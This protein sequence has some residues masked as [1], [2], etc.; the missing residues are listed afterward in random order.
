MLLATAAMSLP[1][2][3][4]ATENGDTANLVESPWRIR[5]EIELEYESERN[6]NLDASDDEDEAVFEPEFDLEISYRPSRRLQGFVRLEWLRQLA[7]G[8]PKAE[9]KDTRLNL[10]EA[11]LSSEGVSVP[12]GGEVSLSVGRKLFRDERQ[13]LYDEQLDG[14]TLR[15]DY[16]AWA[17]SL[18][19]TRQRNKDLLDRE[20]GDEAD[21]Y[22]AYARY[23]FEDQV[24]GAYL[25]KRHERDG[26]NE[27]PLFVGIQTHGELG[28][29]ADYWLEAALARG[30]D[31]EDTIRGW[32]FD[33]GV[34]YRFDAPL[35]PSLTLGYALGSGDDDAADGV[36][37]AFRQTGMQDNEHKRDGLVS[38]RYLGV[39]LEP[40]LS[41][42]EVLTVGVGF[43]PHERL[44]TQL[45]VH[46]YRQHHASPTLRDTNLDADPNGADRDLGY[47]IDWVAGTKVGKAIEI[48]AVV[49]YFQPGEAFDEDSDDAYFFGT[50]VE[51][52]F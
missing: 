40:E 50:K 25:L 47:G 16:D 24:L 2:A 18:S 22:L 33:A 41:N 7:V 43:R 4:A 13:W 8:G 12:G 3:S 5:G 49:G 11:Y 26:G 45:L 29:S 42:L 52:K 35:T 10:A 48:E 14:L 19:A 39:L 27:R 37:H 9:T 34:N 17:L 38:F 51:Y 36:N 23:R 44:S 6:F 28:R 21:N 31:G 15:Y 1:A 46:R 30:R 32:G 20:G